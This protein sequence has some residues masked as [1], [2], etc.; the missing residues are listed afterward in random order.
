MA[1]IL[2]AR[3]GRQERLQDR[4]RDSKGRLGVGRHEFG[5]DP[6]RAKR[7]KYLSQRCVE[8]RVSRRR[9][10]PNP[11]RFTALMTT[12]TQL[13]VKGLERSSTR[14]PFAMGQ[15]AVPSGDLVEENGREVG[16]FLASAI[17]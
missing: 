3:I 5:S 17:S 11:H 10:K 13:R 8:A 7:P 2:R 9:G 15:K 12:I 16:Y 14:T 6:I 4:P 1:G